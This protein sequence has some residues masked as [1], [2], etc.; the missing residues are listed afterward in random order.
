VLVVDVGG[1]NGH[2]L[3]AAKEL[4]PSA[5]GIMCFRIDQ[6]LLLVLENLYLKLRR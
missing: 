5:K 2:A 1:G 4:C 6:K 3:A